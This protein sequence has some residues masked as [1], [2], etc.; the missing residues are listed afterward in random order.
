MSGKNVRV[1]KADELTE[2]S[3]RING[4]EHRGEVEP[5]TLR[6]RSTVTDIVLHCHKSRTRN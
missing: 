3:M 5:R 4:R 6:V 1:A 2:V